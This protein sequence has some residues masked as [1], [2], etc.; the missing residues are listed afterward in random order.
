MT[1]GKPASLWRSSEHAVSSAIVTQSVN[2]RNRL[3]FTPPMLH[4]PIHFLQESATSPLQSA[5]AKGITVAEYVSDLS[6][7]KCFNEN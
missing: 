1:G 3:A 5:N 2:R 4:R 7:V 6:R